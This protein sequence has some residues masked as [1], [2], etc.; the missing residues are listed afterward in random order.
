M[1][2]YKNKK[3]NTIVLYAILVIAISALM[4]VAI[5]KFNSLVKILSEIVRVMM[6]VIWGIVIA[7][8]LNPI[9]KLSEKFLYRFVF[10]KR[11]KRSKLVRTISLLFTCILF[12]AL[13]TGLLYILIPELISSITNIFDNVTIWTEQ[14]S[15]WI[16]ELFKNNQNIQNILLDKLKDYTN[17]INNLI[18]TFKPV[19]DNI[20]SGAIEL[21]SFIKNFLLGFIISIYLLASKET[22]FAQIKKVLFATRKKEKCEKIFSLSSQIN[23]VFS[24]FLIGKIIDSVIIGIITFIVMTIL[25]LPYIVMISVIVG[26][27]NVIPFFG[28]FIGAIPS[29]LLV[30]LSSGSVKEV[31]IFCIMILLIQQFDGNILG[32]AILG[33]S[34]GL[35]AVWVL[36]SILIGGGLFGF[37]GMVLAV[38]TCAVIYDLARTSI[39]NNLSKKK[40][41]VETDDYYENVEHF[42]SKSNISKTQIT[43]EMLNEMEIP[44][45]E[46]VNEAK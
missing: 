8:L 42:Y 2:I 43:P 22:L 12:I 7:F 3:Y 15:N 27:T 46:E 35:P 37:V 33:S 20:Q 4:I 16:T 32:P 10:K 24:G 34:T 13:V 44:S 26:V 45:A 29:A 17:D 9:M 6:P 21:L 36:I 28:P 40:M 38:P 41:P 14:V 18:T 5:F 19:L 30:L 11:Q 39:Q 25:D 31:V 1:K 23:R